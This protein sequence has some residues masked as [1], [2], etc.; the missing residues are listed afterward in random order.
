MDLCSDRSW[1]GIP[2]VRVATVRDTR[3]LVRFDTPLQSR[4]LGVRCRGSVD[5]VQPE[6]PLR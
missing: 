6:L 3:S 1:H 5:R 4:L 2:S